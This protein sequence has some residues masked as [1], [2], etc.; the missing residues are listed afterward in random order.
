MLQV[1]SGLNAQLS[2][3]CR[4]HLAHPEELLDGQCFKEGRCLFPEDDGQSI[5]LVGIGGDLGQELA[6]VMWT[7]VLSGNLCYS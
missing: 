7:L 3:F 6:V 4:R 5:G 2:E 1:S